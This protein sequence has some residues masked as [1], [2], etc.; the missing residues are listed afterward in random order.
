MEHLTEELENVQ[1]MELADVEGEIEEIIEDAQ[2]ESIE[3]S[4]SADEHFSTA[5][6]ETAQSLRSF[7]SETARA[8]KQVYPLS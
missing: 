7:A 6:I 4:E 8:Q 5:E 1:N 2:D 3:A